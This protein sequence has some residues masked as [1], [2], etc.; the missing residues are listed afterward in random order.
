MMNDE[1]LMISPHAMIVVYSFL[2][3]VAHDVNYLVPWGIKTI[4][5]PAV[6]SFATHEERAILRNLN[7]VIQ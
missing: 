7:D 4:R 1:S 2:P 5:L 3:H 6:K